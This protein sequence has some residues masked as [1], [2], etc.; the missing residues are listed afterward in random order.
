ML[1]TVLIEA[2]VCS[3]M[4]D[5]SEF[6][7]CALAAILVIILDISAVT[8]AIRG[9]AASITRVNCHPWTNAKAKPPKNEDKS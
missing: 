9:M 2:I 6:D 4:S 1:L 5:A 3:T 8:E 7:V